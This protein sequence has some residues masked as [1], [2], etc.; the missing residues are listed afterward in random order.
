MRNLTVKIAVFS[1]II[2]FIFLM[3]AMTLVSAPKQSS[4]ARGSG[5]SACHE[6]DCK[7]PADHVD[8]NAMNLGQC[9]ECHSKDT[10]KLTHT[11]PLSHTHRLNG[12]SCKDCHGNTQPP[13]LVNTDQCF[14]CHTIENLLNNT[15]DNKE[16][17][18]HNSHYGP[19]LDCD[20]CHHVHKPSENFCNQ[21]HE[22][23]FIIPS[24]ILKVAK[25]L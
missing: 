19:E 15:K 10:P 13:K 5:C 17:N 2:S 3:Y 7:V 16:A 24:P 1:G 25:L 12:V 6:A 21:C 22:F 4:K 18:P 14:S 9:L 11:L 20:L 23:T 8:T